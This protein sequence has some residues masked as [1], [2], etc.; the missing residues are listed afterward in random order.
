MFHQAERRGLIDRDRTLGRPW[1]GRR[2]LVEVDGT[3][4][5]GVAAMLRVTRS[6]VH[7]FLDG[8]TEALEGRLVVGLVGLDLR[9]VAQV[10]RRELDLRK[11]RREEV[12]VHRRFGSC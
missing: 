1:E 5:R 9:E 12:G 7:R 8:F 2:R 3:P 11:I 4:G 10:K 6:I